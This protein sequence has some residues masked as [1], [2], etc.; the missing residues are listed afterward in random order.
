MKIRR[1]I[2]PEDRIEHIATTF[3]LKKSKKFVSAG[4]L[5]SEQNPREKILPTTY[6]A[7]QTADDMFFV[8]LFSFQIT[9][10]IRS[11][12]ER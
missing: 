5:S 7:R 2:W 12:P 8:L 4:H 1:L 3:P 6:W 11:L 9:M 10:D